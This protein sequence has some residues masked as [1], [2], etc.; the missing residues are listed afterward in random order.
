MERIVAQTQPCSRPAVQVKC[1]IRASHPDLVCDRLCLMPATLVRLAGNDPHVPIRKYHRGAA[2]LGQ[3]DHFEQRLPEPQ[4]NLGLQPGLRKLDRKS[5]QRLVANH[6]RTQMAQL[7][8]IPMRSGQIRNNSLVARPIKVRVPVV[9]GGDDLNRLFA[10]LGMVEEK[11]GQLGRSG[12]I[13]LAQSSMDYL[14]GKD[15]TAA[16]DDWSSVLADSFSCMTRRKA[17]TLHVNRR[18]PISALNVRPPAPDKKHDCASDAAIRWRWLPRTC[19]LDTEVPPS[20][21][22]ESAEPEGTA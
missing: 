13:L 2:K 22:P 3:L 14:D 1:Q 20:E 6:C 18:M 5:A 15:A 9:L 8:N 4:I 19:A 21:S 11:L 17:P 16:T 7:D 10:L 12:V